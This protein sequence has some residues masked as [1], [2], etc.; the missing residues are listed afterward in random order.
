MKYIKRCIVASLAASLIASSSYALDAV[1][2]CE[3]LGDAT[4]V[5]VYAKLKGISERRM[6]E[7]ADE[8][9]HDLPLL[10]TMYGTIIPEVYGSDMHRAD[11]RTY[12]EAIN[13]MV[14]TACVSKIVRNR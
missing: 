2:E 5:V 12:P 11:I 13:K 8:I 3:I 7:I 14:Y 9:Q 1:E 6:N 4:E 10:Y